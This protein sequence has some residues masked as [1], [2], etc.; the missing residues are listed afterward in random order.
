MK[1]LPFWI[2]CLAVCVGC[3]PSYHGHGV[4]YWI[5]EV[6][7]IHGPQLELGG[8]PGSNREQAAQALRAIGPAAGVPA[9]ID[10]LREG[11]D[12]QDKVGAVISLGIYG[13]ASEGALPLLIEALSDRDGPQRSDASTVA[14][15][16][17]ITLT[18]IG[19]AA[20]A[21]I[22]EL[23]KQ[24]ENIKAVLA[25][26]GERRVGNRWDSY[27]FTELSEAFALAKL[28]PGNKFALLTLV[29]ALK[30]DDYIRRDQARLRLAEIGPGAFQ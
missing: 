18:K 29:E 14:S 13:S 17:A 11:K 27:S 8:N 15:H 4:R 2:G 16:V 28:D 5:R 7:V 10:A 3:G 23:T 19:P 21:A 25:Q 1:S 26:L 30:S 9:C 24:L 22:P 12:Q 20:R 6:A